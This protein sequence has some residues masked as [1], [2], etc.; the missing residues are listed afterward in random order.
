[1]KLN[2]AN[3]R[4]RPRTDWEA[5]DLGFRMVAEHRLKLALLWLCVSL[6]F[7]VLSTLLFWQSPGWALFFIWWCK[8]VFE[9]STLYV[10]SIAVFETPPPFKPCLKQSYQL[11]WSKHLLG[12]LTWRRFS[13]YRSMNL[14]IRQLEG[15]S[16]S[17][18]KTRARLLNHQASNGGPALT[19]LGANIEGILFSG[20]GAFVWFALNANAADVFVQDYS[21]FLKSIVA[22][23]EFREQYASSSDLWAVHLSNGLYALILTL[24]GP[25]YVACGFSVYL[26]ARS[27][28]EAWDVELT[29]RRLA[30]RL[31]R[32]L[33]ALCLGALILFQS[34]TPV[35]YAETLPNDSTVTRQ[36]DEIVNNDPYPT[37]KTKKEWCFLSCD[38]DIPQSLGDQTGA[39]LFAN[40]FRI[41][42]WLAL[43]AVL[44][45]AVYFL[46]RDPAWLATLTNRH[47]TAPK[48]M[49]GMDVTPESLPDDV[50]TEA[51]K[52]FEHDPRAAMSLLYRASLTQLIHQFDMPLR[53]GHTEGE[54]LILTKRV[55]PAVFGYMEILTHHWVQMAY[56]HTMPPAMAKDLLCHGYR[57]TFPKSLSEP[58]LTR[59][60]KHA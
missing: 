21:S 5:V 59:G 53:N 9:Y 4:F 18:Y 22:W 43:A 42:M 17:A 52:L 49:F 60:A 3:I 35:A 29:F 31:G 16:G 12:D 50:A 54:V 56:G 33:L 26:N 38:K 28:L 13:P 11:I 55:A 51:G 39:G 40:G 25:I 1:M 23:F 8:P 34:G 6:P 7:V 47:K 58:E 24:W 44:V 30:Q 48:V 46:F 10:L 57:Q 27:K 20:I 37:L 45:A 14:P 36:R 2:E 41:V 19:F 15:L 32:A